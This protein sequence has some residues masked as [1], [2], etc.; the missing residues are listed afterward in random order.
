[1]ELQKTHDVNLGKYF[2]DQFGARKITISISLQMHNYLIE[3]LKS[4]KPPISLLIDTS[5]CGSHYLSV[6]IQTIEKGKPIVLFYKLIELGEDETGLGL[7]NSLYNSL[8]DD[9]LLDYMRS[10]L[11]AVAT[12]G[13]AVS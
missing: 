6:L 4:S 9:D 10:H 7:F 3:F 11:T 8:Q 1:V 5:D 2:A 13:A 12:D